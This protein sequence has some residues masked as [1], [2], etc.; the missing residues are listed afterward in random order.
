M[1]A[2]IDTHAHVVLPETMGAAGACGP[3]MGNTDG[4]PWFR[5]CG[6]HLHG[7]AYKDSPFTDIALR[8]EAMDR[9]GIGAQILSPNP[10]TYFHHIPP[11]EAANFCRTHNDALAALVDGHRTRL[12]G[13]AALPMQDVDLAAAE[14]GRA[15][16]ELGLLGGYIGTDLAGGLDA[17]EL[18]DFYAACVELD[19]PLMLHPAPSGI[20]GPPRDERLARFDLD[21]VV[22]F[23]FEEFVAVAT[24]ILGGV[25]ERHPDLDV[26][27]SHG[28]GSTPM[29]LA[30]LRRLAVRRPSIPAWLRAEGAFDEQLGRLW[31]DLH[32]TG[33]AERDFAVA[34]LGT[35]RLVF[36]T[37]FAGWDGG[38]ATG[39]AGLEE[40]LSANAARLLRLSERA[41]EMAAY[42]GLGA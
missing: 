6:W 8:L 22:E 5:V 12:G 2:L 20:D 42:L 25:L 9:A 23:S 18:D 34:Q 19:A 1:T 30:K 28:G 14:L 41:P 11:P 27:I 24:L 32:V 40:V 13:F 15:I 17:S 33:A 29:H 21:L 39:A 26:C 4:K 3:E 36:G 31:F 35:D 37:N 16:S 10:L 38:D 7:V